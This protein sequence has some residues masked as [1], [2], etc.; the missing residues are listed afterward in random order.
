MTIATTPLQINMEPEN[1]P[2]N[3][4]FFYNPVSLG[5]HVSKNASMAASSHVHV[6]RPMSAAANLRVPS[7]FEV[8]MF[9]PRGGDE[10]FHLRGGDVERRG[11]RGRI[12][13]GRGLFRRANVGGDR[14]QNT[15]TGHIQALVHGGRMSL[16][17]LPEECKKHFMWVVPCCAQST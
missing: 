1:H 5:F 13:A 15:K 14:L 11:S 12:R 2:W 6:P 8:E 10:A 3:T 16:N 4:I 9:R 17:R 7:I